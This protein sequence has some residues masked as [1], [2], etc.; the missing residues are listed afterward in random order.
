MLLTATTLDVNSRLQRNAR[1][2]IL[3]YVKT[4]GGQVLAGSQVMT[5][6]PAVV[7]TYCSTH[8]SQPQH[9]GPTFWKQRGSLQSDTDADLTIYE[10][11]QDD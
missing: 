7:C 3:K 10:L 5:I 11:K 9:K 8:L 1:S 6:N 4:S 2:R